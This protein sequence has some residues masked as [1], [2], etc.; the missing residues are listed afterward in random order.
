L[1]LASYEREREEGAS[2]L[3]AFVSAKSYDDKTVLCSVLV[4]P[5]GVL[6]DPCKLAME[7]VSL[8]IVRWIKTWFG[9]KE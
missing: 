5:L 7:S 4:V 6:G 2:A 8:A 1:G 3:C 9:G